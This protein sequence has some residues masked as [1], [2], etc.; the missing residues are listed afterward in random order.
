MR[1]GADLTRI[2]GCRQAVSWA[3]TPGFNELNLLPTGWLSVIVVEASP[4]GPWLEQ[5]VN[6]ELTDTDRLALFAQAEMRSARDSMGADERIVAIRLP[7]PVPNLNSACPYKLIVDAG[8]ELKM[9]VLLLSHPQS[10]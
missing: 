4:H 6:L 5:S 2:I 1:G 10:Q 3:V 9:S 7:D 8:E